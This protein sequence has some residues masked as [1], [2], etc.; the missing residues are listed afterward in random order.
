MCLPGTSSQDR[1][2]DHHISQL[3]VSHVCHQWREIALNLPLLW[4]HV[5]FTSESLN[6]DGIAEILVRAK[7]APLYLEAIFLGHRQDRDRC[8]TLQKELHTHVPHIRQLR[9][10]AEPV[11]LEG[12]LK[13]MA[14]P[15]PTLEL[16]SLSSASEGNQ[17]RRTPRHSQSSIPDTLFESFTPRL[18][19]VEL[20][21]CDIN[22]R[23]PLLKGLKYLEILNPSTNTRPELAVWL[24]ALDEMPQLTTLTLHSA[25][26][27][28]PPFPFVVRHTLTLPSLTR[29]DILGSSG[30]CALA[31]AHLDLPA[32]TCLCLIAF[33][34]H[35]SDVPNLLPYILRHAHGPQDTRPLQ[36]VFIRGEAVGTDILAW[37]VPNI[38]VEVH[39]LP[40]LLNKTPHTR[41]ALSFR[42]D[43][44]L[45]PDSRLEILDMV[46]AGL[47]LDGLV[48]FAASDLSSPYV[49]S[50]ETQHFWQHFSPKWP[51]LQCVRL[52][53]DLASGFIWMLLEDS[54][55]REKPLLP[56]FKQLVMVDF[57][58]YTPS[59]LP[60]CDALRKRAKEGV[61]V[62]ILDLRKCKP[63][64]D[65]RA[66]AWLKSL[67]D[68]VVLLPEQLYEAREQIEY[69]WNSTPARVSFADD[70]SSESHRSDRSGDDDEYS[71]E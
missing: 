5:N 14:S 45:S 43:E 64:L 60:L 56:S 2:P 50:L 37:P 21:E 12:I 9:I 29:L 65:E 17:R 57:S 33:S 40:T 18:S 66:E 42:S 4:S 52:A 1:K 26:P 34:S 16:L 49:Q 7:S 28:A 70:V 27:I 15:A 39:D 38:D 46:M 54:G 3:R 58:F 55:G 19:R 23:S 47:P 13:G 8:R 68:I 61:P 10:S 63:D 6:S 44:W 62:K 69:L 20:F 22:W 71:E 59:L 24:A 35:E 31:L 53:P 36:S 51:L 30:D 32:L 11:L 67:S 41:L 25:S 48:M